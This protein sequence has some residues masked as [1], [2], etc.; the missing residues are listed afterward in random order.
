MEF[1]A[2]DTMHHM[3]MT[4]PVNQFY[5]YRYQAVT[6]PNKETPQQRYRIS[7]KAGDRLSDA[8][9]NSVVM[10]QSYDNQETV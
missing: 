6:E 1:K 5:L 9:L 3:A 4:G 10:R 2:R 8:I 7:T